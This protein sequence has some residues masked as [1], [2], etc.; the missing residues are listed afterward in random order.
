MPATLI[1]RRVTNVEAFVIIN[2][3]SGDFSLLT[4]FFFTF[5]CSVTPNL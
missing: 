5:H 2:V 4:H 3:V 1:A